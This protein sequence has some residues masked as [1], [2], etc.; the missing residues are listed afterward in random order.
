[1][2]WKRRLAELAIIVMTTAFSVSVT[3]W[4]PFVK[5]VENWLSDYRIATLSPL[6]PQSPNIVIVTITED[7]LEQFPYRSPLDRHF[8]ATVLK[9]LEGYGAKAI[10]IDILFDQA[11]ETD[12]D[13]ELKQTLLNLRIP[14][15]VGFI[16]EQEGLSENQREYLAD[17]VPA[18]FRG[19]VTLIKDGVDATVRQIYPGRTETASL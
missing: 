3:E 1:M 8:L 17:F 7:T 14:V 9:T 4:M 6:Q 18:D 16:G 15:V 2:Q 11:T 10:G 12:K 19:Y 13:D 5:M